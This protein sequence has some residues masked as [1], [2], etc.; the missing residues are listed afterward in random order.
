M[1]VRVATL[2]DVPEIR[3]G[4]LEAPAIAIDTEFHAERRYLP[5]LFLVQLRL[6]DGPTWIIDP[7]VD[8]LLPGLAEALRTPTWILHGGRWDMEV[9]Q[10]ALGGLPDQ[11]WDTQIAAGLVGTWFPAPYASLVE[12]YLG[13]KVDKSATLSDW[14]R[15]PLSDQQIAYAASDVAQLE[16]LWTRLADRLLELGRTELALQACADARQQIVEGPDPDTAWRRLK[17]SAALTPP[18]LGVLQ[19]IAAW[20]LERARMINQPERSVLGDGSMIELARRQP[21]TRGA[22]TANRRIPKALHK[23]SEVLLERIARAVRRP[24]MAWPKAIRRRTPEWQV[25]AFLEVWAMALGHDC[26]FAPGLVLPRS[27]IEDV[28]LADGEAGIKAAIGPWRAGLVWP[29]LLNAVAGRAALRL[30]AGALQLFS[31]ES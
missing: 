19:E 30:D 28:V 16:E 10:S 8:G 7:L 9:L 4:L 22:L 29:E 25:V 26:S 13:E 31:S 23:N 17:A 27:V 24:S 12:Q 11:V 6:P 14:S 20:R 3:E 2:G 1:T 21:T 5:A 18:Q 15:R